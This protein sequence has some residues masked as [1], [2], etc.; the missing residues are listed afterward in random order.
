MK[1]KVVCSTEHVWAIVGSLA[2]AGIWKTGVT[3]AIA[4]VLT[5]IAQYRPPAVTDLGTFANA[6]VAFRAIAEV[7]L[8]YAVVALLAT[9]TILHAYVAGRAWPRC[10]AWLFGLRRAP[11]AH[12]VE[13]TTRSAP[14]ATA[15]R[16]DYENKHGAHASQCH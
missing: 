5:G 8:A 11:Y 1:S 14:V 4:D 16:E 15:P 3:S 13:P 2:L 12:A 9:L 10:S 7:V 6:R